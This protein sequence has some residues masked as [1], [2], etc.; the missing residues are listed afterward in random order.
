MWPRK[1]SIVRREETS[2]TFLVRGFCIALSRAS[3]DPVGAVPMTAAFVAPAVGLCS[4][5]S[6]EPEFLVTSLATAVSLEK[7]Q[8][9]YMARRCT[10]WIGNEHHA[11]TKGQVTVQ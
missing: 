1:L 3:P 5:R 6:R 4:C 7:P 11:E 2:K 8:G 9:L 10:P